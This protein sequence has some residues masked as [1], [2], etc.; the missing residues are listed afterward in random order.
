MGRLL[1]PCACK[2]DI[3]TVIPDGVISVYFCHV[4]FRRLG[5]SIQSYQE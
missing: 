4:Q 5:W 2:Q 1:I 3:C